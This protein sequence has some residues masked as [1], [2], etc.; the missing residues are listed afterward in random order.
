MFDDLM[1]AGWPALD[2][3][4]VGGWVARF[5]GG[6]TQRA[7][8]VV[9]AVAPPDVEA[10]LRQVEALY[11]A[12]GLPVI[13]Q[14]G[15]SAQPTGLDEVLA[16]RGYEFGSPTSVQT[17]TLGRLDGGAGVEIADAPSEEWLDLWWR[18]DGRG[19]R[20]AMD[21]AV[22]ILAGGPALYASLRDAGGVAAVGRLALVGEWGG[23]Y[24][25]AVREDVRRRGHGAAVLSGLLR[26]G[27]E[28][29]I[30]RAWLH[31]R[32]ENT[33]ALSLYERF[34]FTEASRYHYRSHRG[35]EPVEHVHPEP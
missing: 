25:M 34:G 16:A 29:G 13:F 28:R 26:A 6:V 18:V 33:A 20:S 17:V 4:E 31:V 22:K 19:D 1:R 30:T 9:P 5:S 24:C 10:A 15:P 7:N 21:V 35:Q 27:Q 2:E 3:V 11:A 32:A 23:I 8:A 12:R 14:L